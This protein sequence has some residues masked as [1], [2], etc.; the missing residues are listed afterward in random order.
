MKMFRTGIAAALAMLALAAEPASAEMRSVDP[1]A[2]LDADLSGR[3][4]PLAPIQNAVTAA[5]VPAP[6]PG[7]ESVSGVDTWKQTEFGNPD[8]VAPQ[9]TSS[10]YRQDD[11]IGA[12]EVVF[13]KGAQGHIP[14]HDE[15]GRLQSDREIS[16]ARRVSAAD[17]RP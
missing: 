9:A 5:T 10:T 8:S 7:I 17:A 4:S 2:A 1:D 15:I 12:A 11:L 3:S 16:L 13:G 14:A 6:V